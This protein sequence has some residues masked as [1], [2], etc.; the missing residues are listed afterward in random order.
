MT[1]PNNSVNSDAKLRCA[2]FGAGY[3]ERYTDG[4]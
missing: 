3:A 1:L 4:P 2:P